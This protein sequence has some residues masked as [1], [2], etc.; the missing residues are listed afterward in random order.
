MD[1]GMFLV[2]P[3]LIAHGKV[4]YRDFETFYGPG[5]PALLAGT[6]AVFGTNIFVERSVGLLY[7]VAI[8]LAIFAVVRP[9]GKTLAVGCM[10]LSGCLILGTGLPA[11]AWLGAMACALWSLWLGSRSASNLRCFLAGLFAGLA[12][13]FRVDVGPAVILSALPLFHGM[14]WS[15]RRLYFLGGAIGLLPLGILLLVVGWQPII[16]NL[17]LM[18]VIACNPGRRVPLFAAQPDVL[19]LFFAHLL[20]V[21]INLA[22]GCIAIRTSGR[23]VGN[24]LLLAVALFGIGLTPQASQR[25]DSLHLLFAAFLSLAIL[26]LSLVILYSHLR[27]RPVAKTEMWLVMVLVVAV[28]QAIAPELTIMVRS[29]FAAGF[30]PNSR[31]TFTELDGRSFP[32]QSPGMAAT[33]DQMLKKLDSLSTPGER[34]FVGPGDLRRTNYNDTYLYHLLP[35]LTPASYFLE[36][37]PFSA[38]RPGSRL[39]ADIATADWLVLD[40]AW[41]SWSEPNHSM[42]YGSNAPNLVVQKQFTLCGR[43]GSYLLFHRKG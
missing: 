19:Y 13:V 6:F 3:E 31:A 36:M 18:P 14:T 42:D 30:Q 25:L 37:N 10:F 34:L 41:D 5:N 16:S 39:A 24:G 33:V 23:R 38:N 22:A 32:F 35:K 9:K 20:A 7:R 1:E 21:V 43:F 29:A 26:P 17:F 4:P 2:Y 11:Y 8:L 28:L 12:L 40:R 27:D 15:R